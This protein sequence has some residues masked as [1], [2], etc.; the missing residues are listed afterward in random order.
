MTIPGK[1]SC[2]QLLRRI[3]APRRARTLA[4]LPGDKPHNE[5]EGMSPNCPTRQSSDIDL[6]VR[7]V[8]SRS[9]SVELQRAAVSMTS[10]L[11]LSKYQVCIRLR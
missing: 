3:A 4:G 10:G 5:D 7:D 6:P 2:A 9:M 1:A 8:A 11:L